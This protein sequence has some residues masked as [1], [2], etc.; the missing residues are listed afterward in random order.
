MDGYTVPASVEAFFLTIQQSTALSILFTTLVVLIS[1]RFITGSS[2]SLQNDVKIP[3]LASYWVPI[4]GHIPRILFNASSALARLRNRYSQG[5]FS[6]RLLNSVHTFVVEP[7]LSDNLLEQ[8]SSIADKESVVKYLLTSCFGLSRRDLEVY[9]KASHDLDEANHDSLNKETHLDNLS[10]FLLRDFQSVAAELVSFNSYPTDQS[11]WERLADAEAI[12]ND[13]GKESIMEADWF[14]LIKNFVARAATGSIFGTDFVENFPDIWPH[15]W[16]FDQGI[17]PMA[18]GV[19]IWAPLP[20]AQRARIALRRLLVFFREYHDALEKDMNGEEPG[21]RWQDI[22]NVSQLV[23][24]RAK[25]FHSHGLS[26]DARAACD[27]ALLW[28]VTSQSTSLI[29]W[30]LLELYQDPVLLAHIREEVSQHVSIIQPNHDF[31]GA[32]WVPPHIE[33]VDFSALLD[34]CPLLEAT[35][36]ESL[37]LYGGGWHVRKLQADVALKYEQGGYV[38]KEGSFAHVVADLHHTDPR[39]F[40]DAKVWQV[41]RFLEGN[42]GEAGVKTN[43]VGATSVKR[44]GKSRVV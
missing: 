26:I 11:D 7:S 27:I 29:S 40:T 1:S 4:L 44:Y 6:I 41:G 2:G 12:E 10:Q 38:L 3:P 9:D 34:R 36:L 33:K 13:A 39:A 16:A 30:S 43:S 31:G 32:V 37:R 22:Q 8:P 17:L 42:V 23:R 24:S 15:F 19:P 5:I 20:A 14:G 35:Y 25:I 21:V 28:S 18:L